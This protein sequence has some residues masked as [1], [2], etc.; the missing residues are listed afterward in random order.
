MKDYDV[1]NV[2]ERIEFQ[3]GIFEKTLGTAKVRIDRIEK[4]LAKRIEQVRNCIQAMTDEKDF[5]MLNNIVDILNDIE[6]IV[7][8]L[9]SVDITP[10]GL[11]ET[12][13]EGLMRSEYDKVES[14]VF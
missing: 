14:F 9:N 11:N 12:S 4:H 5:Y 8:K 13:L 3:L 10:S 1:K 2:V 7:D 6:R